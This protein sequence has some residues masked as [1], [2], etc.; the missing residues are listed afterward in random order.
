MPLQ[1]SARAQQGVALQGEQSTSGAPAGVATATATAYTPSI[2]VNTGYVIKAVPATV[3]IWST[4][5]L[6]V[7]ILIA[8][9][10]AQIVTFG[11]PPAVGTS[12]N[13]DV[14]PTVAN[15]TGSAAN[16]YPSTGP[17]VLAPPPATVSTWSVVR[18]EVDILIAAPNATVAMFGAVPTYSAGGNAT[19]T[20]RVTGYGY[21]PTPK[22]SAPTTVGSATAS[23]YNAATVPGAVASAASSTAS[24]YDAAATVG[25][26][27]V[28]AS[29]TTSAGGSGG[30]G[31]SAAVGSV[32]SSAYGATVTGSANPTPATADAAGT[33][34]NI[35]ASWSNAA[36]ASTANATATAYNAAGPNAVPNV[37]SGLVPSSRIVY[38]GT[39]VTV[40]TTFT[41]PGSTTPVDPDTV[42]LKFRVNNGTVT[43]WTYEGAGAIGRISQG[44]YTALLTTTG[45]PGTWTA[46]WVGTGA[47]AAVSASQV[48]VTP[49]PL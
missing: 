1:G 37:I 4:V 35:T 47:C 22:V 23:A 12:G 19:L 36:T 16:P 7:D 8:A 28:V 31:A 6:E 27:A 43:T 14:H 3:S 21:N 5:R 33:A 44:V 32:T 10:N 42:T 17:L 29:V 45:K 30:V 46:E 49:A 25:V 39:A 34:Y 38:A 9:P 2:S 20:A 24:A 40:Q 11:A 26:S 48:V 41:N 13:A 18:Y 15:A